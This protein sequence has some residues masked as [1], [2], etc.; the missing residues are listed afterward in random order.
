MLSYAREPN[1]GLNFPIEWVVS[2]GKG[3]VYN[4]TFG[5]VWKD[6]T[7]PPAARCVAFQ[8]LLIRAIEWLD[9]GKVTWP[10]PDDFPD[11]SHIRLRKMSR[12]DH[13]HKNKETI[14]CIV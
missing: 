11:A 8:T 9:D 13:F 5:H 14:T 7:N 10:L 12:V 6:A 2:Y 1:T 3:R 4:S